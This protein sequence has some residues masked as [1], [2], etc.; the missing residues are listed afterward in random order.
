MKCSAMVKRPGDAFYHQC[1][2][3]ATRFGFC[4]T[5][6]SNWT[7]KPKMPKVNDS[8]YL[9]PAYTVCMPPKRLTFKLVSESKLVKLSWW[10]THEL[11]ASIDKCVEMYDNRNP[12]MYERPTADVPALSI[13]CEQCG[14][15]VE[16]ASQMHMKPITPAQQDKI[17]GLLRICALDQATRATI[18]ERL[19]THDRLWAYKAIHKL[20][21]HTEKI[22]SMDPSAKPF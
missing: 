2:N 4:G 9:V 8:S 3:N 10:L 18:L 7:P 21:S 6:L 16:F 15:R 11:Q 14:E 19:V 12:V 13:S 20:I 5:H 1:G 17:I 22:N